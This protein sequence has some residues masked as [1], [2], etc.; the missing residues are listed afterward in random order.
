MKLNAAQIE[1]TMN[2]FEAQALPDSHPAIQELSSLFGDHTFLLDG[3]G[4][5]ILE[6]AEGMPQGGVQAARVINLANWS[7]EKSQ[8]AVAARAGADRRHRRVTGV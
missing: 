2:Q 3:N 7:D 1:R 6:P 5:N 8:Q 4:L